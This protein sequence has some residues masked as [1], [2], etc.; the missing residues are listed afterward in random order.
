[1]PSHNI[2]VLAGDHCGPEVCGSWTSREIGANQILLGDRGSAQGP[3]SDR[4]GEEGLYIQY[5]RV[6][7]RRS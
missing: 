6:P 1:M 2:V 5:P 4:E 3:Q 7:I